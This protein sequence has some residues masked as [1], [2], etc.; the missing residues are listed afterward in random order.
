M[1]TAEKSLKL[2]VII[3]QFI[4]VLDKVDRLFTGKHWEKEKNKRYEQT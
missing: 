3:I 4:P 1:Y 2:T